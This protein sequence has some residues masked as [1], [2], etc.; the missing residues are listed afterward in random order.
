MRESKISEIKAL[1]EQNFK[2]FIKDGKVLT[3][4]NDPVKSAEL[5]AVEQQYIAILKAYSLAPSNSFGEI[6]GALQS[7]ETGAAT[8]A[9]KIQIL[10]HAAQIKALADQIRVLGSKPHLATGAA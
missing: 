4:A 5:I 6:M 2:V 10:K 3:D 1:K 8:D 9:D 7:A